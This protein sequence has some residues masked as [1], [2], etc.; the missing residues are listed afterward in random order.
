[1]HDQA[2]VRQ[3]YDDHTIPKACKDVRARIRSSV[4]EKWLV[5]DFPIPRSAKG[6]HIELVPNMESANGN[7]H[8]SV[9]E[10]SGTLRACTEMFATLGIF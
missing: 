3:A 10:A 7:V 1:M 4:K 6:S 2:F 8:K 9:T 5:S